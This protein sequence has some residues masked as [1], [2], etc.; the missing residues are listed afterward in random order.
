MVAAEP[1]AIF[2]VMAGM[3]ELVKKLKSQPA[4]TKFAENDS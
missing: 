4:F 3:K 1:L 2:F